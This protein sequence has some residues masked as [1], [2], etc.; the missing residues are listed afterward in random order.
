MYPGC[1]PGCPACPHLGLTQTESAE[2]KKHWLEKKLQESGCPVSGV[3]CP[4]PGQ[5]PGYRRRVC[6]HSKYNGKFWEFG[7]ISK[8]NFIAL[9]NCS[10]H[11]PRVNTA[12]KILSDGLPEMGA[13]PPVFLI[14]NHHQLLLVL[15]STM[16]PPSGFIP[17]NVIE[18]LHDAGFRGIWLHRN[19]SAGNRIL[20]KD[21]FCLLSGEEI[22]VDDDGFA[23]GPLSFA[24]LIPSLYHASLIEAANFLKPAPDTLALDLYCGTGRSMRMWTDAGSAC[25]GVELGGEAVQLAKIN[26]PEALVLRGKCSHRIPQLKDFLAEMPDKKPFVYANPPRTGLEPEITAWIARQNDISRLAY[27]SCSAGTLARDLKVLSQSNFRVDHLIPWDFFPG[28]LHVE[29]LALLSRTT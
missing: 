4:S 15:K 27:L 1:S 2:V 8:R 12:I 22:S 21:G 3:R 20:A 28:T 16:L 6:L 17:G 19:P 11:H 9:R 7:V 18:R 24:Q 29:C 25:L 26:A 10:V 13:F 5:R 23:Y 14:I